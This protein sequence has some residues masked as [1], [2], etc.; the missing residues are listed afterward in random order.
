[1]EDLLHAYVHGHL[2]ML[3]FRSP[4]CQGKHISL[5]STPNSDQA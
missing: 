1:M 3:L 4:C 5:A 2:I